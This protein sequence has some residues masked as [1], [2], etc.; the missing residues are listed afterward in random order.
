ME[1]ADKMHDL[2]K[3]H[4]DYFDQDCLFQTC[5][6][7]G[8]AHKRCGNFKK[9]HRIYLWS[10]KE[11]EKKP[12]SVVCPDF[13]EGVRVKIFGLTSARGQTLN[14]QCGALKAELANGRWLVRTS[15]ETISLKPSNLKALPKVEHLMFHG[16]YNNI[17]AL[18]ATQKKWKESEK[19]YRKCLVPFSMFHIILQ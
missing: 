12:R 9:A 5:S 15:V 14:G 7:L 3:N 2:V 6:N 11:L 18:Y 16:I 4:L 13:A 17:A 10:L 19:W 8:L 1:Y